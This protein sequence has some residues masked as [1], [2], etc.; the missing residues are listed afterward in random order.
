MYVVSVHKLILMISFLTNFSLFNLFISLLR[1]LVVS[2]TL[3]PCSLRMLIIIELEPF[4]L[5]KLLCFS[6]TKSIFAHL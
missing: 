3:D 4:N 5:L 2:T 1:I 6:E